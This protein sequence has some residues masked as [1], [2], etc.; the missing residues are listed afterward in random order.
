MKNKIILL[1]KNIL[2][3][4]GLIFI[5]AKD[6][7]VIIDLKKKFKHSERSFVYGRIK[8]VVDSLDCHAT[9]GAIESV[10]KYFSEDSEKRGASR[11]LNLGG[12]V[13]QVSHI[14]ESLGFSV[15]N[16]DM[17][18]VDQ[19]SNNIR[20]DLNSS[21]DLPLEENTFDVVICQEIIEHVENPWN[22]IR[23]AKKYLKSNAYLV[24]TTPNIT[25]QS[26]RSLFKKT[27]Y[28][29]WFTPDCFSYHIN[30]ISFWEMEMVATRLGFELIDI[31]GSGDY[32]FNKENSNR[33]KIIKRNESLIYIF[34]K[35]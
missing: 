28:F 21:I 15:V 11:L 34:K 16:V 31:K 8:Y 25:S 29:K 4:A 26:S 1:I 30:P 18:V 7:K 5:K 14:F 19:N 32:Y 24:V 22:L 2:R 3:F 23:I 13:G 17:D 27:G 35:L 33:K 20:F 10:I 12:G 9:P 6:D